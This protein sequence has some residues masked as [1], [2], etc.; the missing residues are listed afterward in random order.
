MDISADGIA[1]LKVLGSS[2][3]ISDECFTKLLEAGICVITDGQKIP[4]VSQL[5]NSK[6]DAVKEAYAA[7]LCLLVESARHDADPDALSVT[8]HQDYNFTAIRNEKLVKAYRQY[9]NK[10]QAALSHIGIHPPHIVDATWTLDYCV[11]A[12]SL[13]QVGSFLY[14]IQ[15]HTESCTQKF[16]DSGN[17]ST[18]NKVRFLCT[19]EELQDLV[20]KLR[21]AVRHVE[22]IASA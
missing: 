2:N 8:L 18:V 9:K 6:G 1:G 11:K 16:A 10:L 3:T 7:L 19:Q 13:E 5:C 14:L 20:W 21:D 12:S 22:K 15:L 17:E 4:N